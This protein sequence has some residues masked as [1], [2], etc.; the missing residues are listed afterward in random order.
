VRGGVVEESVISV[1]L[2]ARH[3]NLFHAMCRR[4]ADGI[5]PGRRRYDALTNAGTIFTANQAYALTGQPL[6]DPTS[7]SNPRLMKISVTLDLK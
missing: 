7:I 6:A 4:F 1:S 3:S 2:V 5:S